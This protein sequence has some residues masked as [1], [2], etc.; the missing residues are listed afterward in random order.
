MGAVRERLSR[1]ARPT[2]SSARFRGWD[3]RANRSR[4]PTRDAVADGTG[5]EPGQAPIRGGYTISELCRE[6][7]SR[8]LLAAIH[9]I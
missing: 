9:D 2:V 6:H 7:L 3:V 5:T 1:P 8:E 4:R